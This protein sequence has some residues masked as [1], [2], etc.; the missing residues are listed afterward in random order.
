MNN[1][2]LSPRS[3][4]IV[5]LVAFAVRLSYA[6]LLSHD[7]TLYF[8]E[9]SAIYWN[10]VQDWLDSGGFNYK[11]K[12]PGGEAYLPIFERVPGYTIFLLGVRGLFGTSSFAVVVV[13]SVLDAGTCIAIARIGS[14]LSIR[15]G[16]LAGL[17]A[18]FWPNMII[19][20]AMILT[21]TL[22][23]FLTTLALLCLFR[24]LRKHDI[25]YAMATGICV[26]L[27]IAVR[28]VAQFAPICIALL[29][30]FECL[31]QQSGFIRTSLLLGVFIAGA[32]LPTTPIAYR[33][34]TVF[35]SWRLSAQSGNHLMN[36][37]VPLIAT[38]EN[39]TT[40]K[41]ESGRINDLYNKRLAEE[42][43]SSNDNPF[44]VDG[45]RASYGLE[46]LG[47]FPPHAIARS[48]VEG[49]AVSWTAPAAALATIYRRS[50]TSSFIAGDGTLVDRI[51]RYF[52]KGNS[53]QRFFIVP[54]GVAI[55]VT[56]L[57]MFGML[58]AF[59]YDFR[60]ATVAVLICLY[61]MLLTG[62]IMS[63]KYRLP[64][65]P[66]LIIWFILGMLQL[67]EFFVAKRD[68][69]DSNAA[70]HPHA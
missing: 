14:I 4:G 42:G 33:N 27:A 19:H 56:V 48:W 49:M 13:Q 66:L 52:E 29:I 59:R 3:L 38:T 69:A 61:F 45:K 18:A 20:S 44:L 65:E 57:Q 53:W 23:L 68:H 46:A 5:F 35:D 40:H 16:F 17:L 10:S 25:R 12:V 62:P 51:A 70:D 15:I 7:S 11:G 43:L 9:D 60:F 37:V 32:L 54:A 2:S 41:Q 63:P 47:Q 22:F 64:T 28:P 31:R 26:G 36:W 50:N 6:L 58:S 21:D 67:R 30:L 55:L 34:A 39:G 1:C 8:V 24:V